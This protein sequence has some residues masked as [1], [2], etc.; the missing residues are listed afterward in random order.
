MT[1]EILIID[2]KEQ[3]IDALRRVISPLFAEGDVLIEE[4]QTIAASREVMREKTYD[5]VIL[6]MVIPELEGEEA[7]RT[8]GVEFLNEIYDN[9]SVQKPLQ[10]IG[11]TEYEAEYNQQQAQFRDRL[12]HLLYYSQSKIDW[13]KQLKDKVLQLAKMKENFIRGLENRNKYDVGVICALSEEFDQMQRAFDGCQ[14]DDCRLPGL[15]FLFRT[16]TV[17]TSQLHDV[18]VIA[19]CAEHSDV[20]AAAILGTALHVAAGVGSLFLVTDEPLTTAGADV[21]FSSLTQTAKTFASEED[22]DPCLVETSEFIRRMSPLTSS[23]LHLTSQGAA[24]LYQMLR[25]K[26]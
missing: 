18:K 17:T 11:L 23:V 16:T 13:K 22:Y 21:P 19:A 1:L 7:S 10:I 12:W 8:A 6:D 2:D 9:D 24:F 25:E 14:W 4:A 5:L 20:C 15:P 26:F 3:K